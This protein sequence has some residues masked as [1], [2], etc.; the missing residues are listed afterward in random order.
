MI[1][2]K[3]TKCQVDKRQ[4]GKKASWKNGKLEKWQVD[5]TASRWKDL[6]KT[7]PTLML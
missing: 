2:G 3:L 6:A 4:V 1:K 7:L 5:K